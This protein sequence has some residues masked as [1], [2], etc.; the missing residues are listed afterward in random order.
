MATELALGCMNFGKRTP[1]PEARRIMA[2]AVERGVTLFDTANAYNDGES[3]R[4]VGRTLRDHSGVRVATKVGAWKREGLSAARVKASLDE[5]LQRLGR[6]S[7]DVYYLHLPDHQTPIEDTLGAVAEVLAS[8]KVKAFALSNYASWQCLEILERCDRMGIARPVMCQQ[9]YNL[10]IRQ[11]DLEYLRFASKYRLHTTVYNPLAG[12]L[13]AGQ[14]GARFDRNPLYQKRYLS[15]VFMEAVAAF[16]RVAAD[17]GISLV[18]LAYAW[19][20]QRPGVDSI[21]IGPGTLEHLDAALDAVDVPL[22]D[23]VKA[24]VDAVHL[25]LVGTNTSYAR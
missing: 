15:D 6:D 18:T 4:I 2:R 13:L 22:S 5:S 10:L 8:G 16:D 7:V 11:L 25:A 1:E 17:A 14:Q 3:E 20:A 19:C 23:S 21:L 12:G 9:I 24:A